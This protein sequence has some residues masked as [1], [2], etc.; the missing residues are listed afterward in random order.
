MQLLEGDTY[1]GSQNF[2]EQCG[3]AYIGFSFAGRSVVYVSL[4]WL[5]RYC[6]STHEYMLLAFYFVQLYN[7]FERERERERGRE[8]VEEKE[9]EIPIPDFYAHCMFYRDQISS[10]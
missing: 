5:V 4:V 3:R 1:Y 6:I 8:R 10:V 7:Y 2:R 9:I